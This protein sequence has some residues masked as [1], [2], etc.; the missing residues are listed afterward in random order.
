[1]WSVIDGRY[2]SAAAV[3][4]DS[5]VVLSSAKMP[6][7]ESGDHSEWGSASKYGSEREWQVSVGANL[8][9]VPPAV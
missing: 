7:A 5:E 2:S 1:M 8:C 3:N 4:G 9:N 6:T